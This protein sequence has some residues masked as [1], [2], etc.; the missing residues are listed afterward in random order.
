MQTK[1]NDGQLKRE[2]QR[3]RVKPGIWRRSGADGK[4]RY[5]IT[6]R[7]SDGTQRRQVVEG[8][9]RA[10]ETVL[11]DTKAK[12][13]KG[14]R[15]A[16]RPTLTFGEAAAE[17][18]GREVPTLRPATQA[19][20]RTALD[21]HLLPAWGS[22]RLDR[23][24]AATVA[25]LVERMQTADYRAEVEQR[26]GTRRPGQRPSRGYAPW[27]IRSV[28][29]PAGRVFDFAS[30]RMDWAGTNPVRSS[31]MKRK[32]PKI[33]QRERRILSRE[34]L[35][36][37]LNSADEPYKTILT[38][39]TGLGTRFGETLGLTWG[40]IDLDA[41]TATVRY[42]VDRRGE[43]V[44]LKTA[45]SRRIIEMP[46]SL[47]AA[48][49]AHKLRTPPNQTGDDLLLF[50]T[51]TGAP[52]DRRDV[53]RRGLERAYKLAGLS[54]RPP[55]FHELRHAH[56]S[57]WIADGGDLVEL[58]SRLGHRDPAITAS[59]YSHEFEAAA[60]SPER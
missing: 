11:A 22:R 16:P 57:A 1:G 42:Q 32:R 31:L 56:A 15:V 46:G 9:I 12:M 45:R 58:S 10:A 8:G 27:T 55:T 5:E 48:L 21:T 53:Q 3:E 6:Y 37:L 50:T 39:A 33:T 26:Q 13:G 38:A 14:K 2:I 28:L 35:T 40:D 59:T 41:G 44:E 54:G 60:R 49:R 36:R 23:I 52:I 29:T 19:A 18:M 47:V 24:D 51:R 30:E 7:D 43:R 25:D 34:E 20:Y 4:P 17:W